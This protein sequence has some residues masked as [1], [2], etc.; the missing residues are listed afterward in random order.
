VPES[1][2]KPFELEPEDPRPE[3]A[4][5]P[6]PPPPP[7]TTTTT[8]ALPT[9]TPAS[10]G[11]APAP[12]DEKPEVDT[13]TF[14]EKHGRAVERVAGPRP[15]PPDW[16]RE[17]LSYPVRGAGGVYLLGCAAALVA[18]DLLVWS[19]GLTFLSWLLKLPAL[20][21][22]LRWEI[23]LV[24]MTAAGRDEPVGFLRALALDRDGIAALRRL[25]LGLAITSSPLWVSHLLD[26]VLGLASFSRGLVLAGA[27]LGSLW[28]AVIAVGVAVSEP[29]SSANG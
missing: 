24:G 20:L 7:P 13:R 23:D 4:P 2:R 19:P 16:P 14:A 11:N 8:T 9:A 10:P 17:A 12:G 25:L 28:F 18:L 6:P 22:V 3:R 21:F 26:D 5:S 15:P 27:T 1:P 29:T